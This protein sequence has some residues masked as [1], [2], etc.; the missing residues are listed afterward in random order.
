M[1]A[2]IEFDIAFTPEVNKGPNLNW[3]PIFVTPLKKDYTFDSRDKEALS[4]TIDL[5]KMEDDK[6]FISKI[7]I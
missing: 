7:S 4:F 1:K 3:A 6:D 5:P 2:F